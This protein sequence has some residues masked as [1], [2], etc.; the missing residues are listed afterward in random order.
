MTSLNGNNCAKER[1]LAERSLSQELSFLRRLS[2]LANRRTRSANSEIS[3]KDLLEYL[4]IFGWEALS[5]VVDFLGVLEFRS[6]R[7]AVCDYL[8][9][10]GSDYIDIISRGI[11]DR[12]WFVVRNSVSVMAR[13]GG[14]KAFG[15]IEKAIGH[16]DSR[17]RLQIVRGLGDNSDDKS[18]SI[19]KQLVWDADEIVSQVAITS[20]LKSDR[21]DNFK[22]ITEIIN[23]DR[24][25]TFSESNQEMFITIFSKMGGEYAV[26]YLTTL[27]SG[28]GLM[29]TQTQEFYQRT[30]FKA[31]SQNRS[32]KAEAALLKLSRSWRKGIR[33]M[34]QTAIKER[35][36]II[37]GDDE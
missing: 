14:E 32:E 37:Y 17:V 19:L 16:E 6:H 2:L 23:D 35:R 8:V 12:R 9:K 20:L 13:I 27:I 4:D 22:T 15:Y 24:F 3:E 29:Q 11:F 33:Q 31:L 26:S 36:A 5:V 30:A 18:I 28:W 10:A 21:E 34:A 25:A 1:K 7:E